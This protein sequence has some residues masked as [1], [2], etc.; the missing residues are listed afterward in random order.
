MCFPGGNSLPMVW[1][2]TMGGLCGGRREGD[3]IG[4]DDLTNLPVP[5][6]TPAFWTMLL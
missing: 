5:A 3:L 1:E 6:T 4:S 2:D